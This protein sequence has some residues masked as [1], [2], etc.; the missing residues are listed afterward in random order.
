[1]EFHNKL[2]GIIQDKVVSDKEEWYT[3]DNGVIPVV[4]SFNQN[5]VFLNNTFRK[6]FGNLGYMI[7]QTPN[8]CLDVQLFKMTDGLLISFVYPEQ[9]NG[10][11]YVQAWFTAYKDMIL[12]RINQYGKK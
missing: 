10:I 7:S 9:M 3:P 2:Y 4:Y 12:E 8:V 6:C 5:G 1:M 11:E